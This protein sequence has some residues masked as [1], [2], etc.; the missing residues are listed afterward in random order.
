MPNRGKKKN[1]ESQNS[2]LGP[3]RNR[4]PENISELLDLLAD[5]AS[6]KRLAWLQRPRLH[7]AAFAEALRDEQ[8]EPINTVIPEAE[9]Q[10]QK[11]RNELVRKRSEEIDA[12][13]KK[14]GWSPERLTLFKKKVAFY[15][16]EPTCANYLEVRRTFPEVEI[17]IARFAGLDPLHSLEDEFKKNNIDPQLI[18]AAL[19]ANEPSV[20]KL[21]LRLLE[22]VVA[23]DNLPK[24]GP[25]HIQK[26]R[27]A[28]SDAMVNYLIIVMLESLDWHE[29]IFRVPASLIVLIRHQL[30]GPTAPDLHAEYLAKE[31]RN[32]AAFAVSQILQP[33]EELSVGKLAKMANIPRT[34]AA[35]WLKQEDFRTLVNF[36]RMRKA[37]SWPKPNR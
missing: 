36:G 22:L 37:G 9:K 15:R 7:T 20:D 8:I 1:P 11:K 32:N 29:E 17:Q 6:H 34:T 25:G 30:C 33:G 35:R 2:R 24:D 19:D 21:S 16:Q 5:H 18:A 10:L 14:L 27:E 28:L 4:S 13:A 3:N 31:K 23:R 12:T 26:R